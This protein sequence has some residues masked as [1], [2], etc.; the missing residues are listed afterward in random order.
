MIALEEFASCDNFQADK[1]LRVQTVAAWS[2]NALLQRYSST[3][4]Q[5]TRPNAESDDRAVL[6]CDG[7]VSSRFA[8]A[9][10][11]CKLQ[12]LIFKCLETVGYTIQVGT[13]FVR[14]PESH[15]IVL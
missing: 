7:R 11:T 6:A 9:Q 10:I 3:S 12:R 5:E 13:G 1:L 8:Y 15:S 2:R 14:P 4:L